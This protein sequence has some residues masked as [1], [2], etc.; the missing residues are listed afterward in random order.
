M[1][2]HYECLI[3]WQRS[4]LLSQSTH[5]DHQKNIERICNVCNTE[6]KIKTANRREIMMSF[7]GKEL[8]DMINLGFII[9]SSKKHSDDIGSLLNNKDV[10]QN[11]INN[12]KNWHKGVYF[13]NEITN[14][15]ILGYLQ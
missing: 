2:V 14:N 5:P 7:T 10:P 4:S 9:V 12:L 11:L 13:I 15:A 6:F 3:K 1:W 8:S